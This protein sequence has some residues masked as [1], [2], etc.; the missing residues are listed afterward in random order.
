MVV[1]PPQGL[2]GQV[3]GA[4]LYPP[5]IAFLKGLDL[6][7]VEALPADLPVQVMREEVPLLAVPAGLP[8]LAR[9]PGFVALCGG[10]VGFRSS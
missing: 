8:L 7:A 5:L 3:S 9:F 4:L 6:V 10:G 2:M 1:D